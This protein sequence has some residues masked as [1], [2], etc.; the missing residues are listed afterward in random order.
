MKDMN[1]KRNFIAFLLLTF[2]S[3]NFLNSQ[4]IYSLEPIQI[5]GQMNGYSTSSNSNTTYRKIS[6]TATSFPTDGRGPWINYLTF[7]NLKPK[8]KFLN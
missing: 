6:T 2:L 3:I 4:N 1:L 8:I 5:V 7:C